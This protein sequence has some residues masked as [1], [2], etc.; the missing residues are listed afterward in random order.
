MPA[1]TD[2]NRRRRRRPA[3]SLTALYSKHPFPLCARPP[4]PHPSQAYL[5]LDLRPKKTRAIRRAL[6]KEQQGKLLE[7][8]AKRARAFPTRK[9]ALEA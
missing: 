7:K 8:E 6:T 2:A 9:F 5:P 3:G 4:P 1:P